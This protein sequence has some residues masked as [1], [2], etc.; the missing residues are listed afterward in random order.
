LS[1]SVF[2]GVA[3]SAAAAAPPAAAPAG[4]PR[5]DAPVS[6]AKRTPVPKADGPALSA[7]APAAEL[8]D[9]LGR[10][11]ESDDGID[12]LGF[13]DFD[14]DADAHARREQHR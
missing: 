11:A 2:A 14:A 6:A 13:A 10:Y 12:P 9:W 3:A 1:A 8:L 4:P 5:S 7:H